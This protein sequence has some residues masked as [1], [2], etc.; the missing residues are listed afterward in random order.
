MSAMGN[1]E[2]STCI[3][4][5]VFV[6][7]LQ[8]LCSRSLFH[9]F[10]PGLIL[11]SLHHTLFLSIMFLSNRK[12]F[13]PVAPFPNSTCSSA[14]PS[15]C[16]PIRLLLAWPRLV[17]QFLGGVMNCSKTFCTDLKCHYVHR[18]EIASNGHSESRELPWNSHQ[19]RASSFW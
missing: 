3:Y 11:F 18:A 9:L 19:L 15:R 13:F 14:R 7:D 1:T 10:L 12:M 5:C 2:V 16:T 17:T 8:L 4:I 6:S